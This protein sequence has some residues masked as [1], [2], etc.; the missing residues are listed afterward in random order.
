MRRRQ[1]MRVLAAV[2]AAGCSSSGSG[3]GSGGGNTSTAG[4]LESGLAHAFCD[5]QARCCT[6]C[7]ALQAT[8]RAIIDMR[9]WV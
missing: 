6:E 8:A 7:S 5:W 2:A 3:A 1:L 4:G 9:A